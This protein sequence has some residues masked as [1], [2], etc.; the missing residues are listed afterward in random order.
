MAIIA[1]H[2]LWLFENNQN[3]N[4]AFFLKSI[5]RET[6]F[7]P[8]WRYGAAALH[9]SQKLEGHLFES[10]QGIIFLGKADT[11]HDNKCVYASHTRIYGPSYLC[12]VQA[13][14]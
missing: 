11:V 1:I 5:R 9:R 3:R 4:I 8:R 2:I 6:D 10:R 14:V 7:V 13:R 12:I